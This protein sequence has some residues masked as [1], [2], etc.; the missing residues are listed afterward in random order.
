M[1]LYLK[2]ML[3]HGLAVVMYQALKL[4]FIPRS[5]NFIPIPSLIFYCS[6]PFLL[7]LVIVLIHTINHY[8]LL[9]VV[10]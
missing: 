3:E 9:L 10:S 2:I 6:S 5:K 4:S 1:I 7:L 8:N